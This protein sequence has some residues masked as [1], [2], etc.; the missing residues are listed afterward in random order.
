MEPLSKSRRS[1]AI[2]ILG[3]VLVVIALAPIYVRGFPSQWNLGPGGRLAALGVALMFPPAAVVV[4]LCLSRDLAPYERFQLIALVVLLSLLATDLHYSNVDLGQYF[5]DVP[6]NVTWQ[7]QLHA[8]V[9]NRSAE[10]IPHSYRFLPNG[11]VRWLELLTGKFLAASLIYRLTLTI[12]LLFAIYRY[13]RLYTGHQAALAAILLYVVVF[14]ISIRYYAG[15]LTDPLSHL[16]FVVSFIMLEKQAFGLFSFA[17]LAGLLAKE[18]ILVMPVYYLLFRRGDRNHWLKGGLLFAAGV[19]L[20]LV[21]RMSVS[22]APA[23]EK[24]SGVG[25]E[26]IAI[27]FAGCWDWIRQ[28]WHTA[29]VF[30]LFVVVGWKRAAQ[31]LQSLI[32]FLLPCL[33]TSNLLF[34]H[35]KESRNFMPVVV[36]IAVVAASVLFD[37]RTTN[38]ARPSVNS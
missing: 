37:Y 31:P 22:G 8:D 20:A 38:D 9:L 17:V 32:L 10:V 25:L 29:G 18:S 13:A 28:F 4:C 6:E 36:P 1:A 30:L 7:Q 14:P 26:H 2:V 15:Q 23:Y 34:S 27:N 12:A 21:V 19:G 35:L 16:A 3:I 24:V 33:W 5:H 11:I